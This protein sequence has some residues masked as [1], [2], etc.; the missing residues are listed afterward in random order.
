MRWRYVWWAGL[1]VYGGTSFFGFEILPKSWGA[2]MD[3]L[4]SIDLWLINN[5]AYPGLFAIFLGL[6]LGTV[7]IPEAWPFIQKKLFRKGAKEFADDFNLYENHTARAEFLRC[8]VR[9]HRKYSNDKT[10]SVL[11]ELLDQHKWP[12]DFPTKIVPLHNYVRSLTWTNDKS[13]NLWLF[14]ILLF[15][16]VLNKKE[17]GLVDKEDIKIFSD[18]RRIA[19]KFWDRWAREIMAGR[20]KYDDVRRPVFANMNSI[21]ALVLSEMAISFHMPL[22]PGPGKIDMFELA[23]RPAQLSPKRFWVRW[24]KHLWHAANT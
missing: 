7:I 21:N 2:L 13:E 17:N 23:V 19:S 9:A 12:N 1:G 14:F 3:A 11:K 16:D 15:Q 24:W 8:L 6:V 5:A 18:S 20:V 4:T 22:D 10:G